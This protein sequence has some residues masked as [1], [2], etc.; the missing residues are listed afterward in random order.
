[1]NSLALHAWGDESIRT[2]GLADP[3]YLLGAVI[4]DPERCEDYRDQ[5]RRLRT[6]G[7]KL[8]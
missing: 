8:H 4:A 1:M 3:S 7:P 5:L 2:V 6:S